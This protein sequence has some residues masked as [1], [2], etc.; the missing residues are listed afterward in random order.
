LIVFHYHGTG[1]AR[2]LIIKVACIPATNGRIVRNA[3]GA[4]HGNGETHWFDEELL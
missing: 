3:L 1:E 4:A 2:V